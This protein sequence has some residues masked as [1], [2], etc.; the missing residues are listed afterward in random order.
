MEGQKRS[1][2]VMTLVDLASPSSATK[3][4][5]NAKQTKGG[6]SGKPVKE[7]ANSHDVSIKGVLIDSEVHE[8]KPFKVSPGA[9]IRCSLL[10]GSECVMMNDACCDVRV[11]SA[12]TGDVT[13]REWCEHRDHD[14]RAEEQNNV[15]ERVCVVSDRV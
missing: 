8:S 11:P 13:F 7:E 3:A 15:R 9:I 14:G 2:D 12:E 5:K 1:L 4:S 6:K 10:I